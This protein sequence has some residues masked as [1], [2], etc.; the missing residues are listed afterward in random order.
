MEKT[1]P[2]KLF[3]SRRKSAIQS[4]AQRI[5]KSDAGFIAKIAAETIAE[6]MSAINRDFDQALDLFSQ[7]EFMEAQLQHAENVK[8]IARF[9]GFKIRSKPDEWNEDDGLRFDP[10][11]LNLVTSVFGL[12]WMNDLPGMLVQIRRILAPDGL[13]LAAMPGDQTLR[14]LRECLIAAETELTGNVSLRVEPFGEVRQYGNLLQRA[15]FTLP[16][17]DSEHFTVRYRS[18]RSLIDDLRAMGATSSLANAGGVAARKLFEK[19]EEIYFDR[20]SDPDGKIR[21]TV[22]I[23][24]LSG[25]SPHESQQKPLKPGSAQASLSDFI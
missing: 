18:L 19:C 4:R 22:E 5:A 17:V 6:R 12:H 1:S 21:A 7:F 8:Q 13:L 25:W 24:F 3:S 14:E 11:S 16:V 9:G 10:E 23:V 15:G 20:F 2:T